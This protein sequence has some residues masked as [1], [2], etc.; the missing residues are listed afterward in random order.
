MVRRLLVGLAALVLTV[1]QSANAVMVALSAASSGAVSSGASGTG[2]DALWLGHAWIDGR[3]SQSDVDEMVTLLRNTGVRDLF[4][5]AGP[6]N[7]DGTLDPALRV[8][9]GGFVD[10]VHA[11]LPGVRVQ[12]WLG[13]HPR[14]DQLHL[15][16]PATRQRVLTAVG[17]VLD[18]GF[19]GIH[20]DFEPIGDGDEYLLAMLTETRPL[21]R[22]RHAVLSVSA[23]HTE[24][25]SGLAA[26]LRVLPAALSL[27]SGD[28]LHR[29]AKLVDQVAVMAYDT[30]LPARDA[31]TGYVRRAT[32]LALAAV[33]ADVGLLIGVPTYDEPG[34]Y[35]HP[36][37]ETLAAALRGVRLALRAD[38]PAREFGVALYVDFT[39]TPDEWATYRE[40]WS[41]PTG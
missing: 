28:Y 7:N 37:A 11:A 20:Y 35:H 23:I 1:S 10:S 9:A 13:A 14:P 18:D 36:R 22:D 27:W 30:G 34:L 26:C 33:P 15:W 38:P 8:R 41:D 17:R 39:T 16:S 24:P 32:A 12:A 5:H 2:H 6:F 29:V 4:V 25:W 40:H 31:Y 19:D 21:T 3:K